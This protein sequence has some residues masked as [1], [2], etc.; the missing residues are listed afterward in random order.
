M[1]V[2]SFVRLELVNKGLGRLLEEEHIRGMLG[3]GLLDFLDLFLL[4]QVRPA[5]VFFG[6]FDV[7]FWLVLAGFNLLQVIYIIHEL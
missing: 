3:Q 1:H 5:E 6:Q 4:V 2:E 7:G